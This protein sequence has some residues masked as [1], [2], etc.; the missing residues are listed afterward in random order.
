[1]GRAR[2]E[3]KRISD[4]AQRTITFKKRMVGVCKK[5]LELNI[6]C[7]ADV[8]LFVFMDDQMHICS[9]EPEPQQIVNKFRHFEG[10]F[11]LI[12][13]AQFEDLQPDRYRAKKVWPTVYK[14]ADPP[15]ASNRERKTVVLRHRGKKTK[16]STGVSKGRQ[17]KKT[18]PATVA[19]TSGTRRSPRNRQSTY[20]TPERR[21]I[22]RS[23]SLEGLAKRQRTL[24]D[25]QAS[26]VLPSP[27]LPSLEASESQRS[28]QPSLLNQPRSPIHELQRRAEALISPSARTPGSP[29]EQLGRGLRRQENPSHSWTSFGRSVSG[30]EG[31]GRGACRF[32]KIS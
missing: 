12:T 22:T 24:R 3:M 18:T 14:T 11:R 7:G 31:I 10:E 20:T 27:L 25:P 16:V 1:M 19:G 29:G 15:S 13:L 21:K 28:S 23:V 5:V 8:G 26:L 6:L 2:L 32:S 9:S 30:S 17:S 4:R